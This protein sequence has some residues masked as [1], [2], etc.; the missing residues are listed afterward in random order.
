[1]LLFHHKNPFEAA[2]FT[3]KE[4]LQAKQTQYIYEN[5]QKLVS[6]QNKTNVLMCHLVLGQILCK[7]CDSICKSLVM[8]EGSQR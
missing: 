1:M 3:L 6:Q 4:L 5:G 8:F 7:H 2:D